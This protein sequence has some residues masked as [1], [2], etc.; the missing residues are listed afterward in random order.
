[1]KKS[2]LFLSIII[3]MSINV[4]AQI[5]VTNG[6][7]FDLDGQKTNNRVESET[8]MPN[9]PEE[10]G[11]DGNTEGENFSPLGCGTLLLMGFGAAYALSKK[12]R[13]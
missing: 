11:I 4:A 9:F 10:H 3:A 2:V 13:N 1:M 8:M 7:I 5:P 12:K 6:P